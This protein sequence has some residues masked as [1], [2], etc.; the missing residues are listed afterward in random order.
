MAD[1][2]MAFWEWLGQQGGED[3]LRS[4]AE[5]VLEQLM[6]FEVSNRIQAGR[7]E[8][9]EDRQTYR[10]GY[11]ERPLHTRW[12]TLDLKVSSCAKGAIFPRSWS[13]AG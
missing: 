5:R 9:S 7:Q 1:E 13:R 4:L 11:R 2:S 6:D 10:N 8:R 3:F 12:G